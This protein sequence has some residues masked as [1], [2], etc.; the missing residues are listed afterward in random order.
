MSGNFYDTVFILIITAI[1]LFAAGSVLNKSVI[2]LNLPKSPVTSILPEKLPAKGFSI[3]LV[4]AYGGIKDLERA[5]ITQNFQKPK[6]V[7]FDDHFVYKLIFRRSAK[8]SDL[9]EVNAGSQLMEYYLQFTFKER[10]LVLTAIMG[11]Q[12]L[13]R[14]ALDFLPLKGVMV[15]K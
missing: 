15:I 10:T 7:L 13:H 9:L 6:L 11:N 4:D 2:Q 3:P 8:Y 14:Q 5:T 1:G 12:E